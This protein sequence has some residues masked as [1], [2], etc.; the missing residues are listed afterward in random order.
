MHL[1]VF[2]AQNWA[3]HHKKASLNASL[4]ENVLTLEVKLQLLLLLAST[5]FFIK[6]R[7]AEITKAGKIPQV[8]YSYKIARLLS[9]F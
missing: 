8:A 5:F 4:I 2:V 7:V 9:L 6:L 3:I 1:Q